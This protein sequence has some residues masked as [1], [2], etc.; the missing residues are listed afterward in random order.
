MKIVVITHKT[1][2]L[3]KT[4]K[5]LL[6]LLLDKEYEI[7]GI[8]PEE[9]ATDI[10][11]EMGI[12]TRV[13]QNNRISISL[14]RNIK[15]FF[16]VKKVLQ[17]EKPDIVFNY[18]IKPNIIGSIAAKMAK[19]SR[20]YS[21]VTGLGYIYSSEKWRVKCIRLFC[22]IGYRIA[23]HLNTKV[24]FQ[25]K[26]DKNDFIQRGYIAK[27]KAFVID[28]SGVDME[29]FTYTKLPKEFNFLMVARMLDVKGVEEYCKA[30]EIIKKKY[31][32]VS[33]TFVGE[34][35]NTY[36]GIKPDIIQP[37]KE[38]HIVKFEGYQENVE[39]YI[40]KCKV[41]VLPSYLKEGIPRTLLEALAVGR[42]IITTDVS[43]CKETVKEGEN[44]FL[45]RPRDI[46]ELVE[47][48]EYMIKHEALLQKMGE[49]SFQ[50]AK[51]RFEI[52]LINQK[53]LEIMDL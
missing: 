53:M 29:R 4:R 42:P 16:E 47:K 41:F 48:M 1:K 8:C 9:D 26:D 35:E 6:Q 38:N 33:F 15:Y 37:Y 11:E 23:F 21:M 5:K 40:K 30:A 18:T 49:C 32:K 46:Q 43:G 52:H 19:V 39:E 25:N 20:I 50:Y 34:E 10:L 12:Q 27:D 24:I 45:V 51:K 17:E 28:G 2:N 31:P 14:F 7:V 44:G 13:V 3:A 22:N 36:R